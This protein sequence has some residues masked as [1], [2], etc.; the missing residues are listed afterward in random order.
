MNETSMR[1]DV[2]RVVAAQ[3]EEAAVGVERELGSRDQVAR[4]L[5][6]QK[7]LGALAGPLDGAAQAPRRPGDERELGVEV[8]ARAV[9]AAKLPR[10]HAH[11]ALRHAEHAGDLGARAVRPRADA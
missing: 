4:M 5:I 11:V 7:R 9:V 6:A 1:A 2:A 3:R 10:D 8:V